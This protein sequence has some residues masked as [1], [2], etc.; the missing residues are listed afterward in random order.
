MKS[1]GDSAQLYACIAF[2]LKLTIKRFFLATKGAGFLEYSKTDDPSKLQLEPLPEKLE[3]LPEEALE[4]ESEVAEIIAE[5]KNQGVN[6]IIHTEQ[7]REVLDTA[8]PVDKEIVVRKPNIKKF[9]GKVSAAMGLL[10]INRTTGG[11]I[12]HN[13]S[14]NYF[15]VNYRKTSPKSFSK[16]KKVV[17]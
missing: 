3:P 11:S 10:K 8:I 12:T 9:I 6:D 1:L 5:L 15:D 7:V 4:I 16:N 17:L 14:N 13:S 2:I